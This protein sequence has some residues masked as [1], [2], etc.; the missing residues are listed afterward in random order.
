MLIRALGEGVGVCESFGLL[1][2]R[3][4]GRAPSVRDT[5][6]AECPCELTEN[7]KGPLISSCEGTV[8][9][10]LFEGDFSSG[11]VGRLAGED[12]ACFHGRPWSSVSGSPSE[13]IAAS[14][15]KAGNAEAGVSNP[16]VQ[17]LLTGLPSPT[18][19]GGW[20]GSCT[21]TSPSMM[22]ST[23]VD[24]EETFGRRERRGDTGLSGLPERPSSTA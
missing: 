13:S 5:I 14:S 18:S 8:T 10:V 20:L 17:G 7:S 11:N 19:R 3:C 2:V 4:E 21:S 15:A 1:I 22:G 23:C 12:F 9:A 24:I 16:W 6:A